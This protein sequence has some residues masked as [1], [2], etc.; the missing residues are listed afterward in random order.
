MQKVFACFR[1]GTW[2]VSAAGCLEQLGGERPAVSQ[3]DFEG[4]R[5]GLV[6]RWKLQVEI[7]EQ[8]PSPPRRITN[9]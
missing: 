4:Y 8:Q 6:E 7:Q 3:A 2:T 1:P 5:E 9:R